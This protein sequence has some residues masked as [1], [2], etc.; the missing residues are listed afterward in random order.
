MVLRSVSYFSCTWK[1]IIILS[2]SYR[3]D[4]VIINMLFNI[5]T[6]CEKSTQKRIIL[7]YHWSIHYHVT[8]VYSKNNFLF[9]VSLPCVLPPSKLKSNVGKLKYQIP[10]SSGTSIWAPLAQK[11]FLCCFFV[12]EILY[13][14]LFI[15]LLLLC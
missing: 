3:Y 15:H 6:F 2:F 7:G 12:I 14:L 1:T 8:L 5:K 11:R 13:V 9:R 4:N 10:T